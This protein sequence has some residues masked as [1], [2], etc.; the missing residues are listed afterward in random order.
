MSMISPLR[1][2][3][4]GNFFHSHSTIA[5]LHVLSDKRLKQAKPER[6]NKLF[7]GMSV[8]LMGDFSQLPP[9]MEKT[10]FDVSKIE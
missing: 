9:V 1:I 2:Y 8:V 5:N 7:G 3:Q 4:I 10:L 6:S